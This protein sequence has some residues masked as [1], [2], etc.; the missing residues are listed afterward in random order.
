MALEAR[1][2]V[3]AKFP[4]L[5]SLTLGSGALLSAWAL[6]DGCNRL[7][8][9]APAAHSP[10]A[11]DPATDDEDPKAVAA[12]KI[13]FAW[14]ALLGKHD[15]ANLVAGTRV[16]FVFR[17]AERKA[18]CKNVVAATADQLTATL[19][20]L[21][22]D[23]PLAEVLKANSDPQGGPATTRDLLPS[24]AEKW[25][26]YIGP[27]VYP[28]LIIYTGDRASFDF[29]VLASADGVHGLFKYTSHECHD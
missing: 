18:K 28:V 19:K 26:K 29:V 16:P 2:L 20:C 7:S 5:V 12:S 21:L 8:E 14:L 22:D 4:L 6:G 24:W 13:A 1:A 25:T 9:A 17:D 15:T 10:L 27:K 11:A 23:R 3:T